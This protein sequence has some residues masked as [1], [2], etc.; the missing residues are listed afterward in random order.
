MT[1]EVA[2]AGNLPAAF[3]SFVG[4]RREVGEVRRLLGSGRLLT[5][6]G[7][8]GVGK[9]RLA[10]EVAAASRKAFPDGVWLVDLAPVLDPSGAAAAAAGA[11]RV[12]NLGT[13]PVL[14]ELAG[15]LAGRRTLI[16]LDNCEHLV[17]ACSA[18]AQVLL[19]AAP[20]LRILATSR[21]TLGVTGEHV[22]AVPP[23]SPEEAVKLLQDRAIAIRPEFLVGDTN[24]AEV[25]RL[26]TELDGLPLAIEL[27]A[28]RLRTLTVKQ[29]ADRLEDRFAL[30]T[31]GSRTALPHHRTLRGMIDWSYELCTPAE[32]MLWNRLSVFVGGFGLEA[33]EAVCTGNG[34]AEHEVMDLLDR[35]VSQ[36][37]VLTTEPEGLPRYRLLETIRQ[38]GWERL[39]ESGEADLLL[40]RHRDFFLAFAENV[41]ASW[42]GPGQVEAMA[43]L[44][45]DHPNLL[46]ALERD[47]DVQPRLALASALRFHWCAG[48]FLSEGRRQFDRLLADAP[49]PT[50]ARARALWV[51]AYVAQTQGDLATADRRLDEA[52]ALGEE[53]DDP[54]VRAHVRGFRGV[55][56]HYRGQAGEAMSCY[57]DAMTALKALEDEPGAASWLLALA[58]I[59]SYCGDPRATD[60]GRQVIAA[61]EASGERWGRAQVQ[62]AL[63]FDAW[64]RGDREVARALSMAALDSMQG[65]NDY[66]GAAR[67]LELLAWATASAGDH[68]Q[69]A[70]LMGAAEALWRDAGTAITAFDP[71]M[72]EHH[73]RCEEAVTQSLGPA[74]YA[75]ALRKGGRHDSPARAIALALGSD[76]DTEQGASDIGWNP[77]TSREQQVAELVARCM[78]NRRIAAEL[79]LSPRTVDGHVDRIMTKLGVRSRGQIAEWWTTSQAQ[80]PTP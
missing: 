24:R 74:A 48:G 7:A 53:L 70:L 34:I 73:A 59:Q 20:E 26:C 79:V 22:F 33:A 30:L 17:D 19:S 15:Y 78:T 43:Q 39:A 75:K 45:A 64:E 66:V 32:R 14:E 54:T 9:T 57:E 36:S 42:L 44:R 62:L 41:N 46:A 69:A 38:Y 61:A 10:L 27:A 49:E 50:P 4:R 56:A 76:S 6:I 80:V 37:A 72:A 18:L 1:G 16:V 52:G 23:L 67:M 68:E 60:T 35:L 31:G 63:G 65:F 40:L 13:R 21:H 29:M 55:S 77:L 28:S 8:G 58:C 71:R 2:E 11:L 3:T 47:S 51:A 25:S 5:L 12:P